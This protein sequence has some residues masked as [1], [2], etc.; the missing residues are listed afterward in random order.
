[1][2][3]KRLLVINTPQIL[4]PKLE[5]IHFLFIFHNVMLIRGNGEG[6][7]HLFVSNDS[8]LVLLLGST[9]GN[10]FLLGDYSFY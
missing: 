10:C 3:A 9:S 4:M 7:Y 8:L 2:K 6:T 1:M 5:Q